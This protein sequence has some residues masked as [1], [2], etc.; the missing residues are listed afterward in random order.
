MKRRPSQCQSPPCGLDAEGVLK[1]GGGFI[2]AA[3][4]ILLTLSVIYAAIDAV[5]QLLISAQIVPERS[6]Q[7]TNSI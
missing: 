1:E 5:C 6:L 2:L 4:Q 3:G 7:N